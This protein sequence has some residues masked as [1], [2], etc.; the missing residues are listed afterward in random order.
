[1]N[2][3]PLI[4]DDLPACAA[5]LERAYSKAPHNEIFKE[6]NATAYLENK[7]VSSKDS[8]FVSLDD[9]GKITGF[10]LF[11]ISTWANGKQAVLEEIVV[12]PEYQ[13]KGIGKSLVEYGD[14]FLK[15][16]G[17]SSTMLWAK[18]DEGLIHFYEN[19]GF[20][21]AGDFVVMFKND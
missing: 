15:G 4:K 7:F 1:M 18:K 21:V 3:R 10:I 17:V 8:S 16:N 14:T 11:N 6:G 9:T 2:I 13:N 12:D 20:S 5:I 19:Q